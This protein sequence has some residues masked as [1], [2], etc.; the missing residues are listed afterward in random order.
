MTGDKWRG[1]ITDEALRQFAASDQTDKCNVTIELDL[2]MPKV[3]MQAAEPGNPVGPRPKRVAI[4]SIEETQ[5]ASALESKARNAIEKIV[6]D[7]IRWLEI[8][9]AGFA[10][11]S[12]NELRQLVEI[13]G[14]RRIHLRHE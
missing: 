5:S 9:K 4:E 13:D 12:T 10:S 14:V 11:V 1:R 2:P 3:E 7:K 6:R 8:G